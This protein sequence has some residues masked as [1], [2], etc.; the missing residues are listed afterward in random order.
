MS[1]DGHS[2]KA[3]NTA[4]NAVLKPSVF[5][6][7]NAKEVRGIDFNKYANRNISVLELVQNMADMGFQATS[8]GEAIKLVDQMASPSSL[9]I[10]HL[11][12]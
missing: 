9:Q 11:R 2:D 10:S 12:L 7:E 4:T 6:P 5:S 3:P 8:V 1:A